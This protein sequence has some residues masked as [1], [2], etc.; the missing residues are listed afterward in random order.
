VVHNY[1]HGGA[2]VTLAW[3]CAAEVVRLAVDAL[4]LGPTG[5]G[6]QPALSAST[7]S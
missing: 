5:R 2:G 1:G 4:D 6:W 3:G 7:Q